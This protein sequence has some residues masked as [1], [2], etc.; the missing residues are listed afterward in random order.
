MDQFWVF[1]YLAHVAFSATMP[2]MALPSMRQVFHWKHAG[3][4]IAVFGGAALTS[5]LADQFA[6]AYAFILICSVY[7]VGCWLTSDRL[8][9]KQPRSSVLLL[10]GTSYVPSARNYRLWQILPSLLIVVFF[11]GCV[12]SVHHL[13]L[14]RELEQSEDWLYPAS[15]P[16]PTCSSQFPLPDNAIALYLGNS[17]LV[18]GKNISMWPVLIP[19]DR[20]IGVPILVVEQDSRGGVALDIDVRGEDGR[21]VARISR[22]FFVLNRNNML[23]KQRPDRSTL[24]VI[25]QSGNEVLNVRYLNRKSIHLLGTFYVTGQKEPV[26]IK[27]MT[28]DMGGGRIVNSGACN[29]SYGWGDDA[30]YAWNTSG[31]GTGNHEYDP[32]GSVKHPLANGPKWNPSKRAWE[33]HFFR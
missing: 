28:Q 31:D 11:S 18:A 24:I 16:E 9:Q 23:T 13:Q 3:W 8:E 33:L 20:R 27:E 6:L 14:A 1:I 4:A 12:Y 15:D 25:D 19:Q 21:I 29:T 22:N 2:S 30:F 26:V 10:D 5:A 32:P 17:R 7:S